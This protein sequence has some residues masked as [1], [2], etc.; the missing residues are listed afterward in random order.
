MKPGAQRGRSWPRVFRGGLIVRIQREGSWQTI[1]NPPKYRTDEDWVSDL[2]AVGFR[3]DEALTELRRILVTGLARAFHQFPADSAMV[4]DSAQEA[5]L[6]I[7]S[8][9]ETYRGDSRFV[10]WALS[11]VTR[12]AL[13][14]MRRARWKDVS[15][16][17]MSEA[18]RIPPPASEASPA[19]ISYERSRLIE[20]VRNAI[21]DNLTPKQ[22][23]AIQAELGGAPPDEI[24]TRLGTNRNALYKL[25]YDGRVRLKQAILRAGWSEDH[26]RS[27]L[28]GT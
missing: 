4:Q 12:V 24:A 21:E 20:V 14:E 26:V 27:V 3:G 25:T 10:T 15:L 13:S 2:S 6:L 8:R 1:T 17:E 28:S 7:I 19:N 5:L 23:D 9:V 18:G 11:I 16:D 22:R